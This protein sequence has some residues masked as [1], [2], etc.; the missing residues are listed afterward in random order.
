MSAATAF[1]ETAYTPR[2]G[3]RDDR[4]QAILRIARD[5]FMRQGYA[6]TSMSA[7]AARLGGSKGTLYNYFPSKEELFG[8]VVADECDAEFLAMTDFQ[9]AESLEAS[10][11][12]FGVGFLRF[13]LSETALGFQRL[14]SAEAER[15]PELGRLFYAA[16]PERTHA[17]VAE[18]LRRAMDSGVLRRAD[19]QLG[20]SFLIG[21]LKAGIH[22]RRL[23]NVGLESDA[24]GVEAHV[25]AAVAL[26][27]DG[28]RG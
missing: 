22:Q 1:V 15:F 10:L 11:H 19:P 4:R 9:P 24:A 21:L 2:A 8:A 26:F 18:L 17:R 20:A 5:A 6:A 3:S 16:G 28:A 13:A 12:R 14:L 27:L 23:W 25:D 7:I